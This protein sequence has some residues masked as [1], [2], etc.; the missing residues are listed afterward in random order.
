MAATTDTAVYI[1]G[2][3]P[4]DVQVEEGTTGVGDPA[5]PVRMVRFR[6]IAALVSDVSVSRPLGTPEDLLVHEDLLDASAASAPVLPVRFGA[7][8]TPHLAGRIL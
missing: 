1:Y 3:V 7:V 5:G 2:I 4:D 8:V 6:D